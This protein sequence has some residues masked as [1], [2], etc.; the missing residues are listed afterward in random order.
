MCGGTS[1]CLPAAFLLLLVQLLISSDH[2]IPLCP[3][4]RF[5]GCKTALAWGCTADCLFAGSGSERLQLRAACQASLGSLQLDSHLSSTSTAVLAAYAPSGARHRFMGPLLDL[6]V[7][8]ADD[9]P[10][11]VP[12]TIVHTARVCM[13]L[14]QYQR[15]CELLDPAYTVCHRHAVQWGPCHREISS[16]GWKMHADN[17]LALQLSSSTEPG[18]KRSASNTW[19]SMLAVQLP[20]LSATLDDTTVAFL[21]GLFAQRAQSRHGCRPTHLLACIRFTL[22]PTIAQALRLQLMT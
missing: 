3:V 5:A 11:M 8:S 10:L 19:I 18:E 6:Q 12:H 21:A 15:A 13:Q 17:L 1:C 7:R 2:A 14:H 16:A 9:S 20:P 22:A 4:A